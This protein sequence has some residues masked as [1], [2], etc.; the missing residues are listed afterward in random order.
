VVVSHDRFFLDHTVNRVL[1]L[2]QGRIDSYR[3]NYTA[4]LAE[5]EAR[6]ELQQ[7]TYEQQQEMIAKT[8]DFIRRNLAGQKTKQAKSRRK[9]LERI[10]R[11]ASVGQ[12]ETASFKLKPTSR[13][14]DQVMILEHLAIGFP[15]KQLAGDLSLVMR[16][17]ERLGVIGGNGT[18]KTTFLRTIL[19][20]HS[21]LHGKFRWGSGVSVGITTRR[22]QMVDDRHTAIEEIRTVASSGT[23]DGELR[24]FLGGF[25]SVEMMSSSRWRLVRWRKRTSR[26]RQIDLFESQCPGSRRANEPSR[27]RLARSARGCSQ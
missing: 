8:E 6:R 7:R 12:S 14:G 3:G 17:G 5:R 10:D 22:L 18:G 16:R 26:N 9:M 13:T 11:V 23:S 19:G 1:D 27:H 15:G 25:S 20:E 2:D 4:F 21:A 24:G